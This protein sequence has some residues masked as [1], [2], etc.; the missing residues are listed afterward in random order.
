[1]ESISIRLSPKKGHKMVTGRQVT[2]SSFLIAIRSLRMLMIATTVKRL[3]FI[4]TAM[5]GSSAPC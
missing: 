3:R 4:L 1:M 2:P 5:S